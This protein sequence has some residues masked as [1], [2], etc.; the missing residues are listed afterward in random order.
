MKISRIRHVI[1]TSIILFIGHLIKY[2]SHILLNF[3]C[4]V[5]VIALSSV[6]VLSPVAAVSNMYKALSENTTRKG[7]TLVETY[8][9]LKEYEPVFNIIEK[10]NFNEDFEKPLTSVFNTASM[11]SYKTFIDEF[12]AMD[13]MFADFMATGIAVIYTDPDYSF[14]QVKKGDLDF[15]KFKAVVGAHFNS[16]IYSNVGYIFANTIMKAF[17]ENIRIKFNYPE[18]KEIN[19]Q[20]TKAEFQAQYY[21]LMNMFEFVLEYDLINSLDVLLN[22][23]LLLNDAQA[24]YNTASQTISNFSNFENLKALLDLLEFPIVN[25]IAQYIPEVPLISSIPLG[26]KAVTGITAAGMLYDVLDD[27]LIDYRT[28][29]EKYMPPHTYDMV[30]EYLQMRGY[31]PLDET[32]Q[33]VAPEPAVA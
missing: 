30:K 21:D 5:G 14:R 33:E 8:P 17:E 12:N 25:K 23:E 6:L 31:I 13:S 32:E 18:D 16:Q 22:T 7:C 24:W 2:R 4:V 26:Q 10:I 15:S 27:W 19:L 20:F 29:T 1:I 28:S 11:G 9:K 3:L